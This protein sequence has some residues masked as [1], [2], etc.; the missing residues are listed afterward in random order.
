[1]LRQGLRAPL[2]ILLV[3]WIGAT[4]ASAQDLPPQEP[5]LRI[6]PGMHT[7]D[8]RRISVNADCT[9]LATGSFD[10]TV[11]LWSLPEGKA[12]RTLRPP[13]GP[14]NE[15]KIHAVAL[16]PDAS[17]VAAGGRL[18]AQ[19]KESVYIFRAAT[20][21]VVTRLG[22]LGAMVTRLCLLYTSPSPRDRTRSRMPSS[23]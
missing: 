4:V 20:G 6:D 5:Q 22:S 10:K 14:G 15:G 8:V 19:G 23:A 9:L 1:M 17:W 11:R 7:A 3:G 2:L 13:I 18:G 21:E 12:I 16:A